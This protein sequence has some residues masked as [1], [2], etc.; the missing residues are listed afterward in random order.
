MNEKVTAFKAAV[1]GLNRHAT[2]EH[3]TKSM[4]L[5]AFLTH[6]TS[7]LQPTDLISLPQEFC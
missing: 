5:V 7:V 4:L 2:R 1:L 3:L 6:V